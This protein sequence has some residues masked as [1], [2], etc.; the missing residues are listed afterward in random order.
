MIKK[1]VNGMKLAM[2]TKDAKKT[3]IISAG[4]FVF[5]LFFLF[6]SKDSAF[7]G[8]ILSVYV[9]MFFNQ[10]CNML[11]L[12]QVEASSPYRKF[13]AT[14]MQDIITFA[15]SIITGVLVGLSAARQEEPSNMIVGYIFIAVFLV[16][17]GLVYRYYWLGL[18]L[19]IVL[20]LGGMTVAIF[21]L[22]KL[23]LEPLTLNQVVLYGSCSIAGGWLI[24]FLLRRIF[25]KKEVSQIM[26]TSL[27][28]QVK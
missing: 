16:Y 8:S 15:G 21:I 24:G 3:M 11:E 5:A 14:T 19:V 26:R 25:W 4:L 20:V 1:F 18:L 22:P 13:M 10:F 27:E 9:W 12:S 7:L 28:R 6:V 2:T 23:M 17:F